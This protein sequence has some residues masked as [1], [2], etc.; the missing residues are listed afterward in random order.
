MHVF[1]RTVNQLSQVLGI[2]SPAMIVVA[3]AITCQMI[4]IRYFIN[5]SAYWH[6]EAVVYLM[7]GDTLHGLPYVQKL[8]GHVNV[9]LVPM[10]SPP[11]GR[12]I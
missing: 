12:K 5:G 2:V 6:T 3:V 4:F 9:Q 10:L 7:V 1:I 8:K 11:L